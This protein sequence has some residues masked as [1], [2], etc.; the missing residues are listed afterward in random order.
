[1]STIVQQ[2]AFFA[3]EKRRRAL[4]WEANSW[5]GTPFHAH[6][7]LKGV[8]VDCV[9]LAAAI[10]IATGFMEEFKPGW[11][12]LDGGH[13]DATSRVIGWVEKSGKFARC[14]GEDIRPGDL[15]VMKLARVPHHV[16][17]MMNEREFVHALFKM[18]V[19]VAQ[20]SEHRKRIEAVYRPLSWPDGAQEPSLE[21]ARD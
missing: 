21:H 20:L 16:G 6:G 1:M 17:V 4:E 8:G 11:Y 19:V 5:V 12:P 10:Y 3:D 18:H 15:I 9:Q 2:R 14:A 13:H 7:G